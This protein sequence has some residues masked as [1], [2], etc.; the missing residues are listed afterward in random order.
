MTNHFHLVVRAPV[1][2]KPKI[3]LGDFK[4]YGSRPLTARF[5][6]PASETWWTYGGSKRKLPDERAVEAAIH[7]V[8]YKQRNPLLPWAPLVGVTKRAP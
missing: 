4:A 3:I 5:G 7:Y 1:A 2:V 8:L 6:K